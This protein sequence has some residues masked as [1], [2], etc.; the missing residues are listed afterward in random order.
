MYPL[1][2]GLQRL[3]LVTPNP[4]N[5]RPDQ[6]AA[7]QAPPKAKPSRLDPCVHPS[8]NIVVFIN[9]PVSSV[10]LLPSSPPT[11]CAARRHRRVRLRPS[12][13]QIPRP[14]RPVLRSPHPP[15]PSPSPSHP[16]PAESPSRL[17]R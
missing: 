15:L 10:F 11:S 17:A 9:A 7:G 1:H 8:T 14:F 2:Q 4:R 6:A 16:T 5:G 12:W 13:A 3:Y